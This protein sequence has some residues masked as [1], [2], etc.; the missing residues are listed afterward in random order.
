MSNQVQSFIRALGKMERTGNMDDLV[1]LFSEE[2]ELSSLGSPVP[3]R[4]KVGVYRFWRG[5][6]GTFK[7]I[8]S[9]FKKV[10]EKDN[11]A[12]LEWTSRGKLPNDKGFQ[13][14][15]VTLLE[16]DGKKVIRFKAYYDT[17]ML[18]ESVRKNIAA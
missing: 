3:V 8:Q 15:G 9:D 5:Y 1:P 16:Y 17:A 4:G 10:I 13:Y 7:S 6:L 11:L 14:D 18:V 2:A 12:V